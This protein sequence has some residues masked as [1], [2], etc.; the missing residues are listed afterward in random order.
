MKMKYDEKN[1]KFALIV[2][3]LGQVYIILEACYINIIIDVH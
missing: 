3:H 1:I 2:S